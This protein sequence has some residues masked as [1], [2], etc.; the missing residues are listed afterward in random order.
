MSVGAGV[1]VRGAPVGLDVVLSK[2]CLFAG[3]KVRCR[4]YFWFGHERSASHS[5]LEWASIQVHGHVAFDPHLVSPH[6]AAD[7]ADEAAAEFNAS[8][9]ARRL[10]QAL[11][12]GGG[13]GGG[14]AR[15]LH[16]AEESM[17]VLR[18]TKS[19]VQV[20]EMSLLVAPEGGPA[21]GKAG[22]GGAD[23]SAASQSGSSVDS[24][25]DSLEFL[26]RASAAHR[27]ASMPD[28]TLLAGKYGSCLFA[29][30]PEVVA[31]AVKGRPGME[32]AFAYEARL[33]DTLPPSYKGSCARYFYVLTL[34][35]KMKHSA[36]ASVLHVPLR[37]CSTI[38]LDDPHALPPPPPGS[39]RTSRGGSNAPAP[40]PELAEAPAAASASKLRSF[41]SFLLERHD[42]HVKSWALGET[43]GASAWATPVLPKVPLNINPKAE[44]FKVIDF[45]STGYVEKERA[46]DARARTGSNSS[47]ASQ[48]GGGGGG[49]GS[50][51]GGENGLGHGSKPAADLSKSAAEQRPSLTRAIG[52][53]VFRI[54]SE[55]RHMAHVSL[56]KD[57]VAPGEE[58]LVM[59]DFTGAA[60]PCYQ[61]TV[62]LEVEE[63]SKCPPPL[64]AALGPLLRAQGSPSPV[65][66]TDVENPSSFGLG[67]WTR[68][69]LSRT[70][71]V[72]FNAT[73]SV[74]L[75]VPHDLFP[76][77]ETDLVW[78][79]TFLRFEFV[80]ERKGAQ[81]WAMPITNSATQ[82][83]PWRM[84]LRVVPPQEF[85]AGNAKDS[86][87]GILLLSSCTQA[88][89][90]HVRV[91]V[92]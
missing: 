3:D 23:A 22:T 55:Q 90:L 62:A 29:S 37:V 26:A 24:Y 39:R 1:G 42:F 74:I 57:S 88:G 16:R 92:P 75:T 59:F 43:M 70:V 66:H 20:G 69:V 46:L 35:C 76:D 15:A 52:E 80:T 41:S 68:V 5:L 44:T 87:E 84:P 86:E 58:M 30:P 4:V 28:V 67:P 73:R 72:A 50:G 48:G 31:C 14:E 65:A 64:H 82:T 33:P 61:V 9:R 81:P 89:M 2:R 40:A 47:Y 13:E 34:A 25:E 27:G 18:K 78:V 17:R 49:G 56:F 85:F 7:M 79:R 12:V 32:V 71:Q 19:H 36:E 8:E 60:V 45:D 83:S 11:L 51:S 53:Q 54:G 6:D 10:R 63:R 21:A 91:Y 38:G 77:F